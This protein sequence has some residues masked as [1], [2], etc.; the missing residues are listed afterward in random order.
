[1]PYTA[2]CELSIKSGTSQPTAA[3]N[4]H[5]F[6]GFTNMAMACAYST[7]ATSTTESTTFTPVE[8]SSYQYY[9][10][11]PHTVYCVF[12]VSCASVSNVLVSDDG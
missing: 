9:F 6:A 8:F 11:S 7:W 4:I 3:S 2:L 12:R 1:M 10:S 5:V